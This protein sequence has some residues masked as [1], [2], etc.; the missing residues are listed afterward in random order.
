M[1]DCVRAFSL[2]VPG[3]TGTA[4]DRTLPFLLLFSFTFFPPAFSLL[5][6]TL[7]DSDQILQRNTDVHAGGLGKVCVAGYFWSVDKAI[8][9]YDVSF[10]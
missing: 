3:V 5:K 8:T 9:R 7:K 2:P 1:V 10:H 6:L 4:R